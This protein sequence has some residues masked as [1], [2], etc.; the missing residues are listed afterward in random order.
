MGTRGPAPKPTQ[1][2]VL[3]GTYR[4]D[5]ARGEVFPDPPDDLTP[6]VLV[7]SYELPLERDSDQFLTRIS[8]VNLASSLTRGRLLP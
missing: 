6:P 7:G 8:H 5:R 1:L 3:Q 2:K 4:L